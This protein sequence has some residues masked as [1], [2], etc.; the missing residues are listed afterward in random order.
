MIESLSTLKN[1]VSGM[2]ELLLEQNKV[3]KSQLEQLSKTKIEDSKA[4]SEHNKVT[5]ENEIQKGRNEMDQ[6]IAQQNVSSHCPH[7]KY[8][9]C[10]YYKKKWME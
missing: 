3:H 2:K 6:K 5:I 4:I 10:N 9:Y 1:E 7:L 8:Y